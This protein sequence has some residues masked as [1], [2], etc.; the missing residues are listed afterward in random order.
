V[1]DGIFDAITY[2]KGG[3]CLRQ[4]MALVGED[5]FSK[6]LKSYFTDLAF[7]NSTLDDLMEHL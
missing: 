3:A 6:G 2:N 7:K 1:A 5:G 4:L